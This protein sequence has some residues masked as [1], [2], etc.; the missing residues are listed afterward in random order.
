[1]TCIKTD[2]NP[3]VAVVV[4]DIFASYR[5]HPLVTSGYAESDLFES[6]LHTLFHPTPSSVINTPLVHT[7]SQ[8]TQVQ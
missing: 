6:S 2:P 4:A 5:G 8:I 7:G 1:M 3:V